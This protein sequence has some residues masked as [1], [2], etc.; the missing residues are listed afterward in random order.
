MLVIRRGIGALK[1]D[2]RLRA[3]KLLIKAGMDSA[4]K[5][6][7]TRVKKNPEDEGREEAKVKTRHFKSELLWKKHET[8][9]YT[10]NVEVNRNVEKIAAFDMDSTLI[11]TKSGLKFAKS[12]RDW[13]FFD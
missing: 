3:S 12:P 6:R 13:K 4:P 5:D 10:E 11:F 9:L 2:K 8:L 1:Q 7:V